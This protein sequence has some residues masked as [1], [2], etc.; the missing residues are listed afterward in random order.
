MDWGLARLT[1][2]RPRSGSRAQMEAPGPVGTPRLHGARA[3][4]RQPRRDG[5][6]LRRLRA[7]RDALRDRQR[8]AALRRRP[9]S[10]SDAD[11][12]ARDGQVDP[13]RR[14]ARGARRLE[15]HPRHRRQGDAARP[16]RSLPERA[17]SCSTTVRALPARRAAPAARSLPAGRASSSAKATGR[18]GVHDRQRPLPRVTAPSTAREE[19][20]ATWSR[21]TCSAR[22]RCSLD[23]PR[24]ATVDAVDAV[25]VLVLDKQTMTEGLGRR[26]LDRRARA[27]ARAAL[28]RSRATGPQARG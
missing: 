26:R 19:T 24:A 18:R 13:D 25:T 17:S 7:R 11:A 12:R 28:P 23:E 2:T 10:A 8:P 22:W 5:R 1:K 20:L 15:A 14:G 21:A 27:R 4:A 6:A 3:G 9:R 16:E